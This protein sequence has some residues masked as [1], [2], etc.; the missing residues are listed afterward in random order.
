[1]LLRAVVSG[2]TSGFMSGFVSAFI[3]GLFSVFVS[4]FLSVFVSAFLS[5]FEGCQPAVGWGLLFTGWELSH[6]TT[7]ARPA[8]RCASRSQAQPACGSL[9]AAVDRQVDHDHEDYR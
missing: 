8:R 2:F 3:S 6:V 4:A 9:V 5:V 7:H 1:M